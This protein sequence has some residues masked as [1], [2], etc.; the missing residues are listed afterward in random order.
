MDYWL[1]GSQ[2][3]AER[4]WRGGT[5]TQGHITGLPVSALSFIPTA[6]SH[7]A[8]DSQHRAQPYQKLCHLKWAVYSNSYL[9]V[10]TGKNLV[11]VLEYAKAQGFAI[12][13]F[14]CTSSST[15]IAA[16]EGAREAKAP[17]IIQVSQGGAAFF[18]GKGVK[19]GN[20]EASIAGATAAA[21]FV[22]SIAPTYGIPVIMH[23][24]HCAKK[25]LPWLDGML[26][27]DEEY[28]KAH[29]E[30]LYSS[31]MI[32]LSEESKE[33]NIEICCKYFERMA[34]ID[35]WLE[36][37]IGITG[38]EEDGV[39]NEGVDNA[40]LYTQPEDIW[41]V[42]AAFSKI[43]PMFSI[44]AAFGNVHGV[45]KP[46][47]V[48]LQPELLG[49]HQAY[50]KEK[51][52]TDDPRPLYLVFHG[53]SGSTKKEIATA[54][55]NGV[56]KMNVDTDTQW[57]YME[58]FRNYFEAKKEYLKTQVGNPEGPD[59]PNKKSYDPRVWVREGEKTM[60]KR[61]IEACQDLKNVN[62]L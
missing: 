6:G 45:Y 33:E 17:V 47:N 2:S 55:A 46:G 42:Y 40:A 21:M 39:N 37:E 8:F 3:L 36:M 54:L 19:N 57:A 11:K 29:H 16:L 52:K 27:A 7:V 31:H 50:C 22:R 41:D 28:Y 53:G 20:Q 58:G 35:L 10:V 13:A 61:V 51:L 25:L 9:G 14:N 5:T 44:A 30:P 4:A 59:V 38:G 1:H 49:K 12:P 18:A 60:V 48:S 23:S 15:V 62:V 26:K 56:V 43:S 34:K 24:D 32:D